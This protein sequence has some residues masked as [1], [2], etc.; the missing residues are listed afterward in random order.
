MCLS[1]AYRFLILS[2]YHGHFSNYIIILKLSA[3]A[4]GIA[5]PDYIRR[6][7][8]TVKYTNTVK[9]YNNS[10]ILLYIY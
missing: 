2:L 4:H 1:V 10:T 8:A 5:S 7:D 3:L 9:T 6:F